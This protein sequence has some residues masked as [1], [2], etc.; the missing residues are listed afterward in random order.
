MATEQPTENHTPEFT[1]V[2]SLS[3]LYLDGFCALLGPVECD[4]N[5]SLGHLETCSAHFHGLT[6]PRSR[7]AWARLLE[8]SRLAVQAERA[9]R[10]EG[11]H[12][13]AAIPVPP[14]AVTDVPGKPSWLLQPQSTC[15]LAANVSVS[16]AHRRS[17]QRSPQNPEQT[18]GYCW[19]QLLSFRCGL[20]TVVDGLSHLLS[21]QAPPHLLSSKLS[22]PRSR[23]HLGLSLAGLHLSVLGWT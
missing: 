8:E 15:Q 21:F 16:P 18:N 17:L 1:F 6:V 12:Q 10:A 4:K 14:A 23:R 9:H 3:T 19:F 2:W 7:E 13:S 11:C 20:Y 5:S 22:F